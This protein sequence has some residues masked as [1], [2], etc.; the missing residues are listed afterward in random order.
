MRV[1][2]QRVPHSDFDE[3]GRN[4]HDRH[5]VR[6]RD[7]QRQPDD[8]DANE[9]EEQCQNWRAPLS[10]MM[11]FDTFK[12]KPVSEKTPTINPPP[13]AKSRPAT[14]SLQPS[15]LHRKACVA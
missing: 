15:P 10:D 11:M 5:D 7:R 14:Y 8:N 4:H 6:R 12:P 3:R 9:R 1:D 13:R 2:V